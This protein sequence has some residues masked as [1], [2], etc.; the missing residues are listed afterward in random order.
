MSLVG[1]PEHPAR[2]EEV[3]NQGNHG[4]HGLSSNQGITKANS[5]QDDS[6]QLPNVILPVNPLKE[7]YAVHI[8]EVPSLF[9]SHTTNG[10]VDEHQTNNSAAQTNQLK[11]SKHINSL[12]I[13]HHSKK[14]GRSTNNYALLNNYTQRAERHTQERAEDKQEQAEDKQERA[15]DKQAQAEGKQAQAEDRQKEPERAEGQRSYQNENLSQ[16]TECITN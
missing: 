12:H 15:E 13:S 16:S 5:T 2:N 14:L 3:N 10:H 7:P 1:N 8:T 11:K 9:R 6:N 4:T